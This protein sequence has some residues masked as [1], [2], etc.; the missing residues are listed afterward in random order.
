MY[1][2]YQVRE[3]SLL[4]AVKQSKHIAN[5]HRFKTLK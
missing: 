4:P 3:G 2:V 5:S 1:Q